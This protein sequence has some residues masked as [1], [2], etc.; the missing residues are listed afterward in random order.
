M[1][2]VKQITLELLAMRETNCMSTAQCHHFLDT[3]TFSSKQADNFR[4]RHGGSWQ[5]SFNI[6]SIT[7]A[8][9][10]APEEDIVVRATDHGYEITGGGGEDVGAGDGVG[11]GELEGGLG[12]SDKVEGVA[13]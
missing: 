1:R 13:G 10:F 6:R 2:V 3:E 11:A 7:D 12:A 4:H 5:I 9:V 8:V